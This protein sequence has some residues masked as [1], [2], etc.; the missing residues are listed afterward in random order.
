MPGD[1]YV[2][3]IGSEN[4]KLVEKLRVYGAPRKKAVERIRPGDFIIF[5]ISK[6]KLFKG[7]Y[8]VTS[9]WYKDDNPLWPDEKK[10]GRAKY[11]WR[12]N[13]EPVVTGEVSLD[14]VKNKLYFIRSYV[15]V[16]LAFK[17]TPG[18]QGKPI[19]ESDVKVLLEEFKKS[20]ESRGL[21]KP[22][23]NL[24][25]TSSLLSLPDLVILSL[26]ASGKNV[27]LTGPPGSG[28]TSFL[29]DFMEKIGV[30]YRVETGNPEW[31]VYDTIGGV[32]V[33]GEFRKGFITRTVEE[34]WDSLSSTKRPVWLIIDEINR[35]NVDMAFGKFFT[36][37][38]VEHRKHESLAEY[39]EGST[40]IFVP[41]SFRILATM[42]SFDRAILHKMGYALARRFAIIHH[43]SLSRLG[44][45]LEKYREGLD[46]FKK[47]VE[48][49]GG[50]KCEGS[51]EISHEKVMNT[52]LLANSDKNDYSL[53]FK[54]LHDKVKGLKNSDLLD[55]L[56]LGGIN[57]YRVFICI[58][59]ELNNKLAS[60]TDCEICPLRITPGLVADSLRLIIVATI[61]YEM[62]PSDH[63]IKKI[64]NDERL[65]MLILDIALSL[66]VIPQLDVLADHVRIQEYRVGEK[67]GPK[68]LLEDVGKTLDE[69]GLK[70]SREL[71]SR[72][73][74]GVHVF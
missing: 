51:L 50:V 47:R 40:R 70:I 2:I 49:F 14:S 41:Y 42:N 26:L 57:A 38:D 28:K 71:I 63:E 3:S 53:I 24:F 5:Y 68:T 13:I 48:K 69:L 72:I 8:R 54:E 33:K 22:E 11:V 12:V 36:L 7:I 65:A 67:N 61:L 66:N 64:A 44:D 60:Y 31:T 62:L 25:R 17:G 29:K 16:G 27:L 59:D 9:D 10:A 23:E 37:M 52:L 21:E 19:P 45:L 32:T 1:Y 55:S 30:M 74:R 6:E 4:W 35:A 39:E 34:S 56:R 58:I 46:G 20:G 18:N 43:E 15:N 73:S